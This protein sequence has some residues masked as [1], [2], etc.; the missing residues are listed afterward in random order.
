MHEARLSFERLIEY[1]PGATEVYARGTKQMHRSRGKSFFEISKVFCDRTG[2]T[3][4]TRFI[5]SDSS[6]HEW[7]FHQ[8]RRTPIGRDILAD[9][10]SGIRTGVD[11]AGLMIDDMDV[12]YFRHTKRGGGRRSIET[13]EP[14]QSSIEFSKSCTIGA[15]AIVVQAVSLHVDQ[16]LRVSTKTSSPLVGR[17]SDDYGDEQGNRA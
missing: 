12:A 14:V 2:L 8:Q 7:N 6:E 1:R 15:L 5:P 16:S 3:I 13:A 17:I 11:F 4:A 10:L 9:D